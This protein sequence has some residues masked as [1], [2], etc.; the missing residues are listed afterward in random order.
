MEVAA[1]GGR[2]R[3]RRPRG[4]RPRRRGG[5][6]RRPGGRGR[7]R[8]APTGWRWRPARSAPP[9]PGS[10]TRSTAGGSSM[11]L[12]S[13]GP[14]CWTLWNSSSTSTLRPPSTG[15]RLAAVT[16]SSASPMVREAPSGSKTCRSGWASS[17]HSSTARSTSAPRADG[18]GG[19]QRGGEGP[20][21]GPLAAARRADQ[22]VG[23]HRPGRGRLQGSHG[24]ALADHVVPHVGPLDEGPAGRRCRSPP[25]PGRPSVP[26]AQDDRPGAMSRG[27][28]QG[29]GRG[30]GRPRR[31]TRRPR[32]SSGV[33]GRRR[34]RPSGR[35]RPPPGRG[36]RRGPARGTRP[37]P[38]RAGPAPR[39]A[40]RRRATSTGRSSRKTTSASRP[41][42]A[43]RLSGSTPAG[44]RPRPWPW[45]AIEEWKYRSVTTW[46]PGLERRAD[47]R[48][49][50]L[51]PV[52]GHEQRLG[53]R[54]DDAGVRVEEVAAD[55]GAEGR[56]AGLPGPD[57]A[58]GAP[59]RRS[60]WVDLPAASPPS[61]AR[62]RPVI[63]R[64]DARRRLVGGPGPVAD[65]PAGHGRPRGP[66]GPR[67]ASSGRR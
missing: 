54:V 49:D 25:H 66:C 60:V 9:R 37:P 14:A 23:V 55:G 64:P 57:G 56:A 48:G 51:G 67:R 10:R 43:Q 35:G 41:S 40:T 21:R 63:R 13:A 59:A 45:Y 38:P 3:G 44:S 18:V 22:Q 53:A 4:R 24:P 61:K 34:R 20:G 65:P 62:N 31:P 50:V 12:R 33:A 32:S 19:E 15:L 46:R 39:R 1:G 8:R 16:M 29:R 52:G 30:A 28:G 17:R 2:R 36:S 11:V 27:T 47:D 58:R 5:R 7:G 42:V 26:D 6:P